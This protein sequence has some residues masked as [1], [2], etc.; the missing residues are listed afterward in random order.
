MSTREQKLKELRTLGVSIPNSV[1]RDWD[2]PIPGI[3][4][5]RWSWWAYLWERP[6]S[7]Q[8]D[9]EGRSARVKEAQ[10]LWDTSNRYVKENLDRLR[11]ERDRNIELARI[12]AE[13]ER[14]AEQ[15]KELT[16]KLRA[17][18]FTVPG[19]T[20][21]AFQQALPGLLERLRIEAAISEASKTP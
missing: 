18:Y 11:R 9:D 16:S 6:P 17:G 12:N 3:T 4:T 1:R 10:G 7:S 19:A 20:E 21:E 14:K 13:R 2:M 15:L 8:S 5:R